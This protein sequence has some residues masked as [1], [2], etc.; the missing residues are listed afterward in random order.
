MYLASPFPPLHPQRAATKPESEA[1]QE[2]GRNEQEVAGPRAERSPPRSPDV[3]RADEGVGEISSTPPSSGVPA[4][5][6]SLRAAQAL[7]DVKSAAQQRGL[8]KLAP[9]AGGSVLFADAAVAGGSATP[10]G[11]DPAGGRMA[12]LVALAGWLRTVGMTE[13]F[14]IDERG[15]SLLPEAGDD[16]AAAAEVQPAAVLLDLGLRLGEVL[17]IAGRRLA[18]NPSRG[19]AGSRVARL[20]LEDGRCL[21]VARVSGAGAEHPLLGWVEMAHAPLA[22]DSVA[23]ACGRVAEVLGGQE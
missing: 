21:A 5:A 13:F 2:A 22:D 8:L 10:V 1:S 9:E 19:P 11:V 6:R 15:Y 3:A 20:A 18:T 17:E 12:A 23:S 4:T 16:G 7:A 14:L